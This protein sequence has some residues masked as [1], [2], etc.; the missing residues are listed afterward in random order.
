MLPSAAL[1]YTGVLLFIAE[2]EAAW[3]NR[4][5]VFTKMSHVGGLGRY[6]D[7]SY[8]TTS[9]TLPRNSPNRVAANE[10]KINV[11]W[12]SDI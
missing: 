8:S 12:T 2:I 11:D 4:T 6:E 9:V 10:A 1:L 3:Q 5:N 7:P